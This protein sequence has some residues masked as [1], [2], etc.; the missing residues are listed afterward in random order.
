MAALTI[1][2]SYTYLS[3]SGTRDQMETCI[4]NE[5]VVSGDVIA[6]DDAN[7]FGKAGDDPVYYT[8]LVIRPA[9]AGRAAPVVPIRS[10]YVVVGYDLSGLSYGAPVYVE[11]S[12]LDTAA[13]GVNDVIAGRVEY[14]PTAPNNKALRIL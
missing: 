12:K 5:N 6:P 11:G 9:T 10:G 13:P 8:G 1:H 14:H 2:A 3:V 7:G 4:V